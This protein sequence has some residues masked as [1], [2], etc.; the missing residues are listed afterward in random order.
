MAKRKTTTKKPTVTES[1]ET[2]TMT[3]EAAESLKR[4]KTGEE[5]FDV[6]K[7]SQP[8]Q[9]NQEDTFFSAMKHRREKEH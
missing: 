7:K 2:L 6:L 5:F 1:T 4:V 8:V 9:D 3:P